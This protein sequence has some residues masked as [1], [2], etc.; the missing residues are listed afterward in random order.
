MLYGIPC[1]YINNDLILI[2]VG[3]AGWDTAGRKVKPELRMCQSQSEWNVAYPKLEEVWYVKDSAM[4]SGFR[5]S[6]IQLWQ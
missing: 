6:N 5:R 1:Q 3:G 2:F 4:I